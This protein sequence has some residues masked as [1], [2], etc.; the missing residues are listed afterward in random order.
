[1]TIPLAG[2]PNDVPAANEG[3]EDQRLDRD[4]FPSDESSPDLEPYLAL[5]EEVVSVADILTR[6]LAAGMEDQAVGRL[7]R[8][9]PIISSALARL[10]SRLIAGTR[11]DSQGDS[12]SAEA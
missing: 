1:V 3:G 4:I 5:L 2:R 10:D 11:I 7:R 8:A 12:G 6:A 9:M